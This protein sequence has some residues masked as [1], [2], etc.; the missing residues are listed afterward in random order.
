M[1]F[2]AMIKLEARKRLDNY[3]FGQDVEHENRND[4]ST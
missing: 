1:I 4:A 2:G 3:V